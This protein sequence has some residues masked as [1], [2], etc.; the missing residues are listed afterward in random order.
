M[1]FRSWSWKLLRP[2][3]LSRRMMHPSTPTYST[4]L[5]HLTHS[6]RSS[7][8]TTNTNTAWISYSNHFLVAMLCRRR[9]QLWIPRR[10]HHSLDRRTVTGV[11]SPLLRVKI[12]R[13][14]VGWL[15]QRTAGTFFTLSCCLIKCIQMRLPRYQCQAAAWRRSMALQLKSMLAAVTGNCMPCNGIHMC[16]DFMLWTWREGPGCPHGNV[17][18]VPGLG[19]VVHIRPN[20]VSTKPSP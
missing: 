1:L 5:T 4:T 7:T 15:P 3:S 8:L 16:P 10:S 12:N 9:H 14:H 11:P 18:N 20:C 17:H 19:S 2:R 13:R 6:T